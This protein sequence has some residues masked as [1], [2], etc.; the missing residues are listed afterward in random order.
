MLPV[1]GALCAMAPAARA[2]QPV[3]TRLLKPIRGEVKIH[4]QARVREPG[5]A[6][7]VYRNQGAELEEVARLAAGGGGSFEV[8]DRDWRG[9][10]STYQLRY[11]GRD[12]REQVLATSAVHLE[13]VDSAPSGGWF[14]GQGQ[15]VTLAKRDQDPAPE[16]HHVLDRRW[17]RGPTADSDREPPTPP[18]RWFPA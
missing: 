9:G 16:L 2:D 4:W 14:A 12:H 18:P 15:P 13:E 8:V 7:I 10:R 11:Q 5:G 17:P 3:E 1:L 6:F